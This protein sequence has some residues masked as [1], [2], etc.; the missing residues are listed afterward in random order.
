MQ[1]LKTAPKIHKFT[2]P[3]IAVSSIFAHNNYIIYNIII[4]FYYGDFPNPHGC[5]EM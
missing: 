1:F 5:V 2:F 3:R 4:L